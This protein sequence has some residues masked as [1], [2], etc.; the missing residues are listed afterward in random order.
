MD[1]LGHRAAANALGAN[2]HGLVRAVGRRHMDPLQIRAKHPSAD[3]GHLRTHTTEV[4]SLTTMSHRVAKAGLLSA[5]FTCLRHSTRSPLGQSCRH[6]GKGSNIPA[7][8]GNARG[9][10]FRGPPRKRRWQHGLLSHGAI[11]NS[12]ACSPHLSP[13]SSSPSPFPLGSKNRFHRCLS[14]GRWTRPRLFR[15]GTVKDGGRR[16]QPSPRF[17]LVSRFGPGYYTQVRLHRCVLPVFPS[18]PD[19]QR[20]LECPVRPSPLHVGTS[21]VACSSSP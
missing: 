3:A 16:R 5:H 11:H 6:R 15:K 14:P 17:D 12:N 2:P 4:F 18:Y 10:F 13:S 1:A 8:Q 9:F 7:I 21:A 20:L 19:P